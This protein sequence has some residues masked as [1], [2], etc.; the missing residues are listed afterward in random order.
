VVTGIGKSKKEL[1]EL[2]SK[3]VRGEV[4][5]LERRVAAR[6]SLMDEAIEMAHQHEVRITALEDD[7]NKAMREM[8][9]PSC[10]NQ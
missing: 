5:I 2:V 3:A 9:A 4:E 1:Q 10:L 7:F 8:G 6:E